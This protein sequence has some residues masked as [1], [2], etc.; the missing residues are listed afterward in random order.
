MAFA[1][2]RSDGGSAFDRFL[3]G[4]SIRVSHLETAIDKHNLTSDSAAGVRAQQ[5]RHRTEFFG[6][7]HPALY[8][9]A[10]SELPCAFHRCVHT[11][12]KSA[13]VHHRGIGPSRI[14]HV[15]VDAVAGDAVSLRIAYK[16][17]G[18]ALR[19]YSRAP[20][21]R[22]APRRSRCLESSPT[23]ARSC[24]EGRCG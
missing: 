20:H 23:F 22:G 9:L 7:D 15:Y 8:A 1:Y 5:H 10:V 13:P 3:F 14:D 19:P 18:R 4:S 21:R 12:C 2:E 6:F 17:S 24:R 16:L 11:L